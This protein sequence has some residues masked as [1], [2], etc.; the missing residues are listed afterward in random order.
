MKKMTNI[1]FGTKDDGLS[2]LSTLIPISFA[3]FLR[4]GK[5]V[6]FVDK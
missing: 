1:C 2:L 5:I 3:D 4:G 6:A